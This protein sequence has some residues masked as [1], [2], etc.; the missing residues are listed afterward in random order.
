MDVKS[1]RSKYGTTRNME[2]IWWKEVGERT[3]ATLRCVAPRG[4][5]LRL[6]EVKFQ[7]M[8]IPSRILVL[9]SLFMDI[10]YMII[11]ESTNKSR[12]IHYMKAQ[13]TNSGSMMNMCGASEENIFI[14]PGLYLRS[15]AS[16]GNASRGSEKRFKDVFLIFCCSW[17]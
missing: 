14:K 1:K 16:M 13:N 6:W 5:V 2:L 3:F 8:F 15:I 17:I 11:D 10:D 4:L 12:T 7:D 9:F